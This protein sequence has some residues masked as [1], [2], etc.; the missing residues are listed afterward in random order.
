MKQFIVLFVCILFSLAANPKP[1]CQS[2]NNNDDKVTIIFTD[3]K[4]GDNYS[5]TD[6]KFIP[7]WLGKEHKALSV[8]VSVNKGIATVTL[9][10]DHTTRFSNPG[11]ELKINGKKT[12]FKVCQ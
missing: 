8:N 11:I 6:V 5:V 2:F 7:I 4:A 3:D 10:F 1:Q 12:S 9:T